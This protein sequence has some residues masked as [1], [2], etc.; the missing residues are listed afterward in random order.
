[1]KKFM[2]T[3]VLASSLTLAACGKTETA[4]TTVTDDTAM[5]SDGGMAMDMGTDM[6]AMPA[7]MA[8]Y[9][10][11]EVLK[12]A[13]AAENNGEA[14]MQMKT[15]DDKAK[16]ME[17][18][19]NQ[20]TAAGVTGAAMAEDGAQS[21]VSGTTSDGQAVS[22]KVQGMGADGNLIMVTSGTSN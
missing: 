22:V 4:D 5:T 21:T 18:Y 12:S 17:Y 13:S 2:I 8:A 20:F 1:M 19:S 7:G 6:S 11:A 10:G 16:V 3:A 9:P 14:M 15:A